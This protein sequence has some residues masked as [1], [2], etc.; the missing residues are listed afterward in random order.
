MAA[1][2]IVSVHWDTAD[3]D[4]M[5]A[6]L[7]AATD[8]ATREAIAALARAVQAAAKDRAPVY[9]G[10]DPRAVPGALRN[11]I[12][13]GSLVMVADTYSVKVMPAGSTRAGI[14]H[15]KR[16]R[17]GKGELGVPLYRDKMEERYGYM[18]AAIELGEARAEQ[19]FEE[20]YRAAF[21]RFSA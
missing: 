7:D 12:T 15:T 18:R 19:V 3:W 13:P 20:A 10:D 5:M 6:E 9:K 21:E 1:S 11:S 4:K 2:P 16:R 17:R 8:A 14:H